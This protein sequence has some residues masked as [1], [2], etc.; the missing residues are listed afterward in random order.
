VTDLTAEIDAYLKR[1]F[2]ITRSITGN[3]NRETLKILREI[4]PLKIKEYSS[5]TKVYDWVIPKEWNIKDAWIK[6]S[7]G[8]KIIDF[9]RSNLHVV[10]Y[11]TPVHKRMRLE[12][13]EKHL[14]RRE[15]L[16]AAIPY[17][18]SYYNETWGFCLCHNDYEKHF[19][20]TETYEVFI[21]SELKSG[22][23]TVGELLI[24]GKSDKEYLISTYI[25]H[26]SLANDNLSGFVMA[27]FL[28][29]ELQKRELH[30]SY[31]IVFVPE[32]IGAIAYCA[33]NEVAM[34][35][36]VA[37]FVVTTVGG[38]GRFGYRQS[39]EQNCFIN[40]MVE[41]TFH[42]NGIDDFKVY[43]FDIHGSDERQYSSQGFRINIVSITKDKYY[44]YDYYHTSQDDLKFISAENIASCLGLYM[45][46]LEKLDK[47]ITY[48]NCSPNCEVMLSRRGLYQKT[49]GGQ[50]PIFGARNEQDLILWLL[51]HADG[52]KS[53]WDISKL[54]KTPI[55]ELYDLAVQLVGKKLLKEMLRPNNEYRDDRLL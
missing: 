37:G 40:S 7:A 33:D 1:L 38:P 42:E 20:G 3:G 17:R 49:G 43:P 8:E 35:R 41:E 51:F 24:K 15:D 27:A 14:H 30:F 5:G 54:L 47:N 48:I 22:S 16:P 13:L 28:S 11:S 21:D 31:R 18:T 9:K 4:V 50:V 26:P 52:R 44:D 55:D 12:E 46:T 34:K 25:C 32:T 10:G 39:W 23:L 19:N 45:R 2:P 6:N 53:L 29:R 36:V